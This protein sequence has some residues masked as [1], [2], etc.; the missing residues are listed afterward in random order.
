MSSQTHLEPPNGGFYTSCNTGDGSGRVIALCM[1]YTMH[2]EDPGGS[3]S[4]SVSVS[5]QTHEEP[6]NGGSYTGCVIPVVAPVGA[7][8]LCVH[9]TLC[10]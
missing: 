10:K 6:L 7:V 2:D 8:V 9:N 5:P 1:P 4:R 3:G